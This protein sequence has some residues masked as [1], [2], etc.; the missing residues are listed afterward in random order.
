MRRF[1]PY[2]RAALLA[3]LLS[4][5]LMLV[6]G[7]VTSVIY[8]KVIPHQAYV[9]LVTLAIGATLALGF[10]L[11]ARQLRAYLID[12]AGRKADLI[13]GSILFRQT[14]ALRMEQRPD[15]A[16]AYSH[17]LA[18]I[19]L[20]REFFASA[21]LSAISDL[22]FI[23]VFVAMVFV[24]GGP[25]GWVLVIAITAAAVDVA[26]DSR[27][28]AP[29]HHGQH[30]PNGR[31]ARRAGGSRGRPGRPEGRRRAGPF[32]APVRRGHRE[33]GHQHAALAQDHGADDEHLGHCAAGHLTGDAGV[34]CVFD[35]RQGGQ[36]RCADWVGDVCQPRRGAAFQRGATGHALPGRTRR[37]ARAG[38]RDAAAGGPRTGQG[39][40]ATPQPQR[41]DGA[42]GG[43]LCLPRARQRIPF[44]PAQQ[45]AR[46][47]A[48]V[49]SRV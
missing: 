2:Y 22:P 32:S 38:P 37:A 1:V 34:G 4:N 36:R 18:Q 16:G 19:E 31:P 29:R 3:A 48:P 42:A 26:H 23:F 20:V 5:V 44:R 7:M 40:R 33:C 17:H 46:A 11:M 25:L 49:C 41:P 24:I 30:E 43:G 15:S 9:T 47:G 27:R 45:G 21:T 10:D 35:R 6:T 28:A 8:D 14:L 12:M 13:V 39:L